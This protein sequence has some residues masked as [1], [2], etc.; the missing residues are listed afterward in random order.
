MRFVPS[1]LGEE[2]GEL[3]LVVVTRLLD[4]VDGSRFVIR[5][6]RLRDHVAEHPG[7]HFHF[8]PDLVIGLGGRRRSCGWRVTLDR[9]EVAVILAGFRTEEQL[10]YSRF[11]PCDQYLQ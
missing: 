3:C 4:L 6:P 11:K 10:S 7:M 5:I 8:S 1:L 2:V 9:H